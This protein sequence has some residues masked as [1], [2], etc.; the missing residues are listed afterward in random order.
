MHRWAWHAAAAHYQLIDSF[1][2]VLR[3]GLLNAQTSSMRDMS[4]FLCILCPHSLTQESLST[5]LPRPHQN[6]VFMRQKY[7]L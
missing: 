4:A 6:I 3:K 5:S 2:L 1:L 7:D